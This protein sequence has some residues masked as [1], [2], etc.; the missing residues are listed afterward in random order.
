MEE[1]KQAMVEAHLG[2][3]GAHRSGLRLHNHIKRIVYYWPTMVQDCINYAK[4]CDAC[5]FHAN[6]IHQPPEPLHLTVASW[7][8]EVWGPDVLGTITPKSSAGHSYILAATNYFSKWEEVVLLREV[9]KENA[10][11]FIKTHII[12]RYSVL[13]DIIADNNKTFVNSML[14]SLCEKLK[15]AQQKSSMYHALANGLVKFFNKTLCNLLKKVIAKCKGIG[16]KDW[17]RHFGH[18]KP[19]TRNQHSRRPSLR[20]MELKPL[21]H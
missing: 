15:F 10:V 13:R 3:C 16:M 4:R 1:A 21:Y 19:H 2:V 6:F 12:Y 7:P 9:N 11:D 5:Q 8:F 14:T 17:G 20:Y 18:I